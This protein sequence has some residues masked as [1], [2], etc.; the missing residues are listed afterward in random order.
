MVERF[1][2]KEKG[3]AHPYVDSILPS[4]NAGRLLVKKST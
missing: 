2:K 1:K 4:P 3:F